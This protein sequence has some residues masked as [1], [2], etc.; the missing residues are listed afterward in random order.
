MH[1]K[2]QTEEE[3]RER[4][5]EMVARNEERRR[6]GGE[7]RSKKEKNKISSLQFVSIL[8]ADDNGFRHATIKPHLDKERKA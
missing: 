1:G 7:T 6:G 8:S 3:E 5:R 2:F 4:E